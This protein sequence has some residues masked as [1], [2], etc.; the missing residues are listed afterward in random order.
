MDQ[1]G[2]MTDIALL[3]LNR[4]ERYEQRAAWRRDDDRPIQPKRECIFLSIKDCK[5]LSFA[6]RTQ[7]PDLESRS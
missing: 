6:E 2:N 3:R 7:F 4:I 1:K 5:W